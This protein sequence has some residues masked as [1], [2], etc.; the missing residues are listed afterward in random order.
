MLRMILIVVVTA[1][2]AFA[3]GVWTESTVLAVSSLEHTRTTI[4][5]AEMHLK[6]NPNDL[7][8]TSTPINNFASATS[9]VCFQS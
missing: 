1:I 8:S 2:V 9:T 4:S 3:A 6:M 5:P 7:F